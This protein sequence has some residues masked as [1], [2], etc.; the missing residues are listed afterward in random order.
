MQ[1]P[2]LRCRWPC[3]SPHILRL[4]P[5]IFSLFPELPRVPGFVGIIVVNLVQYQPYD[6]LWMQFADPIAEG[7]YIDVEVY[8]L[9]NGIGEAITGAC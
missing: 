2:L 9:G 6:Y 1:F 4:K 3:L 8:V 5:Q 7:K